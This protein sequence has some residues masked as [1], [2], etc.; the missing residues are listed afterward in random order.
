MSVQAK[1]VIPDADYA[2]DDDMENILQQIQDAEIA[3]A[4]DESFA[5][6]HN[7]DGIDGIDGIDGKELDSDFIFA[8]QLAKQEQEERDAEYARQLEEADNPTPPRHQPPRH[9]LPRHQPPRN[10][11]ANGVV[12]DGVVDDDIADADDMNDDD[13]DTVYEHIAQQKAQEILKTKGNAYDKP[14]NIDRILELEAKEDEKIREKFRQQEQNRLWRE[15]KDR[16]D[17]EF[18]LAQQQDLAK[19]RAKQLALQQQFNPSGM[20]NGTITDNITNIDNITN[21]DNISNTYANDFANCDDFEDDTE[22]ET[23]LP[24]S[25]IQPQVQSKEELRLARLQFFCKKQ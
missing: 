25:R 6:A 13:V 21:T 2:D 24:Q 19:E 15:E 11:R 3:R 20:F 4:M 8:R 16:Q 14:L 22:L 12:D 5:A 9:Q 7:V 23:Q 1:R 18:R 10:G 17:A